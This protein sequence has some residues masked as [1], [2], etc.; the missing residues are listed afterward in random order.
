MKPTVNGVYYNVAHSPLEVVR[1]GYRYK[2]SSQTHRDKF[3]LK[4]KVR[5]EWLCDSLSRRFKFH[6]DC[7]VIA[8]MQ[9]YLQVETRG[10]YVEDTRT[11][12][13]Y[14]SPDQLQVVCTDF[15]GWEGEWQG[16]G[17]Q[18]QGKCLESG[19]KSGSSTETLIG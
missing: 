13:V 17:L 9:L 4:A 2:F 8:D 16:D 12:V 6:V 7:P 1:Y 11:G 19:R 15:Y 3:A 18:L 10:F 14:E 5:E